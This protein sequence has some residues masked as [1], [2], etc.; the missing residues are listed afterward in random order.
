MKKYHA[1]RSALLFAVNSFVSVTMHWI[2]SLRS[3]GKPKDTQFLGRNAGVVHRPR[4]V[5][6]DNN[7]TSCR[8]VRTRVPSQIFK[9]TALFS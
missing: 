5:T 6:R 9:R 7:G 3:G 1:N 8:R 2:P 4:V